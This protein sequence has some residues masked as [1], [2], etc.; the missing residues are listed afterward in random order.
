MESRF[1]EDWRSIKSMVAKKDQE[2][3]TTESTQVY[4][5]GQWIRPLLLVSLRL[6]CTP[7]PPKHP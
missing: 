2:A 7:H 4:I 6:Q 3:L 1:G 5:F